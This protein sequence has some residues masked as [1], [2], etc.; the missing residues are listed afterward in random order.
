MTTK[1]IFLDFDGP[2]IPGRAWYLN[3]RNHKNCDEDY[4]RHKPSTWSMSF[5]D[6]CAVAF[7]L[8]LMDET[9]IK[10]VISSSWRRLGED[11]VKR[12]LELNGISWS[13]VHPSWTTPISGTSRT[14]RILEWLKK[15]PE[16]DE[17]VAIDDEKLGLGE[18][19]I[20]V[21]L[22]DGMQWE[23]FQQIREHFGV[24]EEE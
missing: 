20:H 10:L 13:Y 4:N 22:W 16:V 5:F 11:S 12:I 21:S 9:S 24:L 17:Y 6:Q 19:L 14:E 23:H 7:L 3:N 15:H 2:V 8:E 1:V 18:N